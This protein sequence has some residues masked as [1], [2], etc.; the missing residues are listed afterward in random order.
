[1]NKAVIGLCFGDEGKG[2]FVDYLCSQSPNALVVRFNGGHQAGHTV[3]TDKTRHVFSNFGSGTLRG[4]STYWS[5]HCTIEP[6][7]I[8]RELELL[9][10]EGIPLNPKLYI[11]AECPVTTPYDMASNEAIESHNLH[12]S[13]G[14]GFGATVEREENYYSLRF[15]DL[16]YP[17]I[18]EAKLSSIKNYYR[19]IKYPAFISADM[20]DNFIKKCLEL[21]S[22]KEIELV[23]KRPVAE[24]Y[25]YE[26]A[27]GLLLD[28]HYGFFPNV[29]RSNCGTVNLPQYEDFE[30][31]LVTRGYQVRHGNGFISNVRDS[32]IRKDSMET[33][34]SH[35][36][37]GEFRRGILDT[38][39]LRYA[40]QR[41]HRIRE[42][43]KK[44]LVITCLDHLEK[45]RYMRHGFIAE[46]DNKSDFIQLISDI[47]QI[48]SVYYSENSNSRYVKN[49]SP[50]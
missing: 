12:G 40:M 50:K 10:N 38:D 37:Q 26:G 48:P 18:F 22:S 35:P 7:G 43:S 17:R 33:N 27:Q 31:Y 39:L 11:D 46:C 20:K 3:V 13:C 8:M 49:D 47:L 42:A 23:F 24:Q 28:Q 14:V 29:T 36:Y 25:I 41:D 34:H 1:M 9:R 2:M 15:L 30:F 19:Y 21:I 5:K 32:V 44:N 45:F 4:C 6:I 16:F